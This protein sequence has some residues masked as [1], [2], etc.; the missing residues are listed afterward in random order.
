MSLY[1]TC[2]FAMLTLEMAALFILVLPLPNKMRKVMYNTWVR[3]SEKQEIRT[4][5]VIMS[6]IVGMLFVDSWKRAN[7]KVNLYGHGEGPEGGMATS[8]QALAGR[9]YNQRNVYISGFI[10]YYMIGIVTVLSIVRRLVK[11][12][13]LIN[14]ESKASGEKKSSEKVKTATSAEQDEEIT[15]LERQLAAKE[16]DLEAMRRQVENLEKHFDESNLPPA[17][18]TTEGRDE[19]KTE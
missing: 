11:Y 14:A 2:L 1:F 12:K 5:V 10:L 6:I 16:A 3:L 17:T 15:E 19:K 13:D 4:I 18:T 9:A 7:V 8:L